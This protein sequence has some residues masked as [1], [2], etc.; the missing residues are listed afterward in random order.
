MWGQAL[1]IYSDDPAGRRW[2]DGEK[3]EEEQSSQSRV[4]SKCCV[5]AAGRPGL[6]HGLCRYHRAQVE[7]VE[8]LMS[9]VPQV[10]TRKGC[11]PAP[12]TRLQH[13]VDS[14]ILS[15]KN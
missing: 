3:T 2:M 13:L 12:R 6:N 1:T 4:K 7:G 11:M 10:V 14:K 9:Y 8:G 5:Q 15:K